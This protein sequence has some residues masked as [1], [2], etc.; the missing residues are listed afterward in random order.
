M[1]SDAP[2]GKAFWRY[3]A[4]KGPRDAA[5]SVLIFIG[6]LIEAVLLYEVIVEISEKGGGFGTFG[7]LVALP[8]A[9]SLLLH[10]LLIFRNFRVFEHL[11]EKEKPPSRRPADVLEGLIFILWGVVVGEVPYLI[12]VTSLAKGPV[13][14][15]FRGVMNG[16]LHHVGAFEKGFLLEAGQYH[17]LFIAGSLA[18]SVVVFLWDFASGLRTRDNPTFWKFVKADGSTIIIWSVLFYCIANLPAKP[19]Q[20]VP[21][22]ASPLLVVGTTL[23]APSEQMRAAFMILTL[24]ILVYCGILLNRLLVARK[25]PEIAKRAI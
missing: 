11:S 24:S 12:T 4:I 3:V 18:L 20:A 7:P 6:A 5:E 23:V 19:I 25:D 15:Y 21:S 2:D 14:Q 17:W 8:V 10:Q 22:P 16:M 13:T 1:S 9:V